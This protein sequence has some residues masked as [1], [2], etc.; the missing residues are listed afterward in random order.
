MSLLA[1]LYLFEE[2]VPVVAVCLESINKRA[3]ENFPEAQDIKNRKKPCLGNCKRQVSQ[4]LLLQKKIVVVPFW[5][6]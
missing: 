3:I 2:F 4:C 6:R 1:R 5:S